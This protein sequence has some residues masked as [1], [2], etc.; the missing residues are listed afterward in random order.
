MDASSQPE[1][2]PEL[3]EANPILAIALTLFSFLFLLA[4]AGSLTSWILLGVAAWKRKPILPVANWSPKPWGLVDLVIGFISLVVCQVLLTT[5]AAPV[6]GVDLKAL[7]GEGDQLPLTLSAVISA[8]YLCAVG[9]IT[10]WL[11]FRFQ[12]N[13]QEIGWGLKRLPRLLVVGLVGGLAFLPILFGLNALVVLVSETE[14]NH[15]ILDSM[16]ADGTPVS[17][18]LASF[19]AAVAAPIAEEFLFRGLLQGWLQSLPRVTLS[20][21]LI[22]RT[23]ERGSLISNSQGSTELPTSSTSSTSPASEIGQRVEVSSTGDEFQVHENSESNP[24]AAPVN[25]EPLPEANRSASHVPPI[26]PSVVAG[27]LFGLAHWGYGLSFIPL[28]FLGIFLGMLYRATQSIWPCIVVHFMLNASSMV[29]LGVNIL[30]QKAVQ[31]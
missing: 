17:F 12:S 28:I 19:S 11:L 5:I 6:L 15:P 25:S 4:A 8:S 30:I 24:F 13:L 27:T 23:I 20:W 9:V 14:Y 7:S 10:A 29:A 22:G 3:L 16:K 31:S 21:A 18:L 1:I 26:W 2:T